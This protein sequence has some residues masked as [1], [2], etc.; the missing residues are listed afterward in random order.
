MSEIPT[1]LTECLEEE[2]MEDKQKPV[3]KII[4][5]VKTEICDHYC[6]WP[7]DDRYCNP[8]GLNMLQ[9]EQCHKCPLS[10]L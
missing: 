6:K 2:R 5:D 9:R 4:D 8:E 3:T 10:R 7:H 1:S